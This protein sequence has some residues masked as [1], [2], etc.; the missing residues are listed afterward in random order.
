MDKLYKL[1][2]VQ[3][4]YPEVKVNEERNAGKRRMNPLMSTKDKYSKVESKLD[5][6]RK[7][8][9]K[10]KKS[11]KPSYKVSID[12]LLKENMKRVAGVVKI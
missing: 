12:P 2:E 3:V 10:K 7:T 5:T 4:K 1:D 8:L 6:E 9:R 11:T